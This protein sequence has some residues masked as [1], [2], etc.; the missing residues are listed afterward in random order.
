MMFAF[1]HPQKLDN[2][3]SKLLPVLGE[4]KLILSTEQNIDKSIIKF[5]NSINR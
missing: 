5:L 1:A 2:D 4:E 3:K